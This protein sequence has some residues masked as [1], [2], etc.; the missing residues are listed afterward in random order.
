MALHWAKKDYSTIRALVEAWKMRA[1]LISAEVDFH[2]SIE[3]L[4][5]RWANKKV[6]AQQQFIS[7]S[8]NELIDYLNDY[9]GSSTNQST[10]W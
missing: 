6:K 7:Q 9:I 1:S 5:F 3:L 4:N 2:W 10:S 8:L